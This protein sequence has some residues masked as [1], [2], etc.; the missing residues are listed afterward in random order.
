M[1]FTL[2]ALQAEFGDSLILHYG[3]ESRKY[4]LID[5]GPEGVYKARLR[6]RLEQLRSKSVNNQLIIQMVM[7][8]HIDRDHITGIISLTNELIEKKQA[9]ELPPF[10]ITKLWH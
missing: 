2:E 1:I 10:K 9:H 6:K 8:S 5:G 7:V 3:T 4:I